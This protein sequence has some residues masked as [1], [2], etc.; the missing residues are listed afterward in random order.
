RRTSAPLLERSRVGGKTCV[1]EVQPAACDQGGAGPSGARRQHTVEEVDTSS[2]HLE[3]PLGV[4][5]A[6]EVARLTVL[7]ERRRPADGVE[8]LLAR[9]PH[10]E[11]TERVAVERKCGDLLE[12]AAPELGV[13]A[14][15][16][17]TE[18]KLAPGP[19]GFDLLLGPSRRD[20]DRMLELVPTRVR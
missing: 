14:A 1:P 12:R 9:L 13:G 17:D 16:G 2:D 19:F 8:H 7:E 10:R 18:A 3:N 6:H 11:T 15:L 4:P 20:L 5:D